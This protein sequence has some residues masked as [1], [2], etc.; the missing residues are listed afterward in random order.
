[1]WKSTSLATMEDI[2]VH[3]Y[4]PRASSALSS[5]VIQTLSCGVG[6]TGGWT[7]PRSEITGCGLDELDFGKKVE[8]ALGKGW[9]DD[10]GNDVIMYKFKLIK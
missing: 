10:K 1:M 6:G 3:R 5:G 9:A 4:S 2:L 8:L 7:F